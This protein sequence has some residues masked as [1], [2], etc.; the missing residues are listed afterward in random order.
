MTGPFWL[1]STCV[2]LRS[3]RSGGGDIVRCAACECV[4]VGQLSKE[5]VD[6]QNI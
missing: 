5:V 2:E 4:S 6:Q 3:G 1:L